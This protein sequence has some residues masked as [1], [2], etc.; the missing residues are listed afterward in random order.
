MDLVDQDP[1]CRITLDL[2]EVSATAGGERFEITMLDSVR[3]AL[4]EGT[5]DS[6]A[7]LLQSTAATRKTAG[8]LEYLRNFA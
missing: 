2:E 1:Q 5:W 8:A 3:A 4:I 7:L 6:T